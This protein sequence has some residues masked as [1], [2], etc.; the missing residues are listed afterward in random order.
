VPAEGTRPA[1][2][3]GARVGRR[4]PPLP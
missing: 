4:P 1:L 3:H 2:R